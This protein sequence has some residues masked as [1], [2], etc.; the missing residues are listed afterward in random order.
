MFDDGHRLLLVHNRVHD[1]FV[2]S[3]CARRVG[4]SLSKRGTNCIPRRDLAAREIAEAVRLGAFLTTREL[5]PSPSLRR[6]LHKR[7]KR[8]HVKK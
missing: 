4:T 1:A 6:L 8:K 7:E 2:W 5:A 3:L